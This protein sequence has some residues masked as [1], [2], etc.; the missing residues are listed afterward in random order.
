MTDHSGDRAWAD[1]FP[2]KT[3]ANVLGVIGASTILL[4]PGLVGLMAE[5][6]ALNPGQVGS[7]ASADLTTMGIAMVGVAF[8]IH[9]V[10]W[11]TLSAI[12]LMLLAAGYGWSVLAADFSSM[13]AARLVSGVGE[14]IAV[15]VAFA[16][17]GAMRNPDR[18]FGIYLVFALSF[19]A[20]GLFVMPTVAAAGGQSLVFGLLLLLVLASFP[21]LSWTPAGHSRQPVVDHQP[22]PLPYAL[23]SLGLATVFCYFLAQGNVWAYLERVGA[24]ASLSPETVGGALALSSL[25]GIGGAC[26]AAV[27]NTRF[28]RA[29]P[30]TISALVSI[31]AVALLHG[32]VS[33]LSFSAAAALFNFAWNV[34]QPLFSGIMAGLDSKGRAVVMM[35][36]IQTVGV[37]LGPGLA[38]L[39]VGE[40][41]FEAV[42]V[43]GIAGIAVSQV[44]VLTL[45]AKS[46]RARAREQLPGVA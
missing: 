44:L 9:R 25:S 16:L 23:V 43:I 26:V 37:G 18:E 12:S 15:S 6:L 40:G 10:H 3:A 33:A 39:F 34:S 31:G 4:L 32:D 19:G 46:G 7:L 1:T 5:T 17:F 28:G 14:G 45:I 2:V 29:W 21:T 36:A 8:L 11:R 38:A 42:I 30:L 13:M 27:I 22:T 20:V 41:S 35:G 24:A